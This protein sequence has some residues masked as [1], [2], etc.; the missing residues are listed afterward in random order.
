MNATS[1]P[2]GSLHLDRFLPPNRS[3]NFG[4]LRPARRAK[5]VIAS[6]WRV[7]LTVFAPAIETKSP[8]DSG[9]QPGMHQYVPLK[10]R[11]LPTADFLRGGRESTKAGGTRRNTWKT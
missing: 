8:V 6:R 9:R 5:V 3:T 1:N 4:Q 7:I 2:A 11:I 10:F